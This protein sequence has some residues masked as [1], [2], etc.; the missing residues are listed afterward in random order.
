MS[1]HPRVPTYNMLL[2][3][4]LLLT[5]KRDE[6]CGADIMRESKIACGSVYPIL[7]TL[8]HNGVVAGRSED[9]DPR[10]AGRPRKRYYALTQKGHEYARRYNA[11]AIAKN[12]RLV[13]FGAFK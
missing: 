5:P 7:R 2:I 12:P 4:G 13:P 8:E 1:M 6:W 10:Q 3:L 11:K 9:I